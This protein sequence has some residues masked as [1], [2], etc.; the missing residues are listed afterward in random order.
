MLR[1]RRLGLGRMSKIISLQGEQS[2]KDVE[3]WLGQL[4][5]VSDAD[6]LL[7]LQLRSWQFGGIASLIQ[8]LITWSKRHPN[9]SL[10]THV[11]DPS[12]AAVQLRNLCQTSHGLMAMMLAPD[13]KLANRKLSIA[14]A[15]EEFVDRRLGEMQKEHLKNSPE[16]FLICADYRNHYLPQLY[17]GPSEDDPHARLRAE[18]E[19]AGLAKSV[20]SQMIGV[21]YRAKPLNQEFA[22]A[23]GAIIYE[24]FS[25][26][27][28]WARD[29]WDRM[30]IEK[31]IRGIRLETVRGQKER[32]LSYVKGN[33]PLE[34]YVANLPASRLGTEHILLEVNIFDSGSGLAARWLRTPVDAMS[35]L[36]EREA[37]MECLKKHAT[38]EPRS[39]HGLG[40]YFVMRQLTKV[41]GFV[42][43][44]T[45]R[46][47]FYRD[48]ANDPFPPGQ[49][50]EPNA[51]PELFDWYSGSRT[52]TRGP[53]VE[54]TLFSLLIPVCNQ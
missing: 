17:Y 45:G 5:R 42:R 6:I 41:G 12:R 31:S 14:A 34:R 47:G 27:D 30:P 2:I 28:R 40:L 54:G 13:V 39:H 53:Q 7:N 37:V 22:D 33:P 43:A 1:L 21:H 48:L 9:A 19:F 10:I 36:Q 51:D 32:L 52:P 15:A 25:N 4:Q 38:S 26:T 20:I 29:E 11:Q 3:E 46:L 35:I 49:E 24:L 18:G 16:K 23:L 44:R 8:L 50:K